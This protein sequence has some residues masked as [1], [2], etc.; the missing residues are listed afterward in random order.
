VRTIDLEAVSYSDSRPEGKAIS[1]A[2]GGRDRRASQ[3]A[4]VRWIVPSNPESR[5]GMGVGL[6]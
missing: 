2:S 4:T 6:F 5:S 3:S 1:H